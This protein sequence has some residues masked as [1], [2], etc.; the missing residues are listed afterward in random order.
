MVIA[1]PRDQQVPPAC[2]ILIYVISKTNRIDY[3]E[4]IIYCSIREKFLRS[5]LKQTTCDRIY[6]VSTQYGFKV[7]CQLQIAHVLTVGELTRMRMRGY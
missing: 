1:N 5:A 4:N 7:G 6:C 2:D 3:C